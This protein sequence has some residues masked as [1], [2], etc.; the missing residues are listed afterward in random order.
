MKIIVILK[1]TLIW[2]TVLYT[3][4]I[5]IIIMKKYETEIYIT[6]QL[7]VVVYHLNKSLYQL[8]EDQ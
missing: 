6:I 7:K 3:V 1:S 5:F 4:N 8:K 2:I